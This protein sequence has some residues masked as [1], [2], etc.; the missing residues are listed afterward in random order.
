MV[1]YVSAGT[2]EYLYQEEGGFH[3]L[4]LNPRLQVCTCAWQAQCL[5]VCV[6]TCVCMCVHMCLYVC[7]QVEHPCTEMVADVNLPALQLQVGGW[8]CVACS[9]ATPLQL[10]NMFVCVCRWGWGFPS[11]ASRTSAHSTRG[12]CGRPHPL[13]LTSKPHPPSPHPLFYVCLFGSPDPLPSPHGHVIAGRITAENPDE[14]RNVTPF[15]PYP[16]TL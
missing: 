5:Y 10:N 2:V 6:C 4:E 14:V 11:T 8:G 7:L 15:D 13:T 1:G 12:S 9:S 16:L 3:F